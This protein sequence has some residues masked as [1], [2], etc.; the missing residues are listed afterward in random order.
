MRHIVEN[1]YLNATTIDRDAGIR[2]TAHRRDVRLRVKGSF[3]VTHLSVVV[4]RSP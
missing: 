1:E 2:A 3:S 4:R